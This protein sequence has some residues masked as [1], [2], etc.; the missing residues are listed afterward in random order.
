MHEVDIV[1]IARCFHLCEVDSS[2]PSLSKA[3]CG[4]LEKC[5]LIIFFK[6]PGFRCGGD[7]FWNSCVL[8][9]LG[10]VR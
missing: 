2:E 4:G 1:I 8:S 3:R 5:S 10:G 9:S 6:N 7:F